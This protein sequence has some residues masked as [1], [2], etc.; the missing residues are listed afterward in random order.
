MVA[1]PHDGS[2]TTVTFDGASYT[3]TDITVNFSDAGGDDSLDVSHLGL[4]S[5][6]NVATQARPLVGGT[7]DTGTECQIEL[8]G[9]GAPAAGTEATLVIS[10]AISI[11]D[12]SRCTASSVRA[13]VNDVVRSSATFRVGTQGCVS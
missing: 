10:G 2:G 12:C 8:L 13:T 11:S 9:G 7:T 4:A 5:G 1:T 6:D 3:V